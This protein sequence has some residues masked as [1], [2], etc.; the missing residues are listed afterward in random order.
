MTQGR[1]RPV[2]W[3]PPRAGSGLLVLRGQTRMAGL[4][5]PARPRAEQAVAR[6]GRTEPQPGPSGTRPGHGFRAW[7]ASLRVGR[8]GCRFTTDGVRLVLHRPS[9][10][11]LVAASRESSWPSVILH[12]CFFNFR[13]FHGFASSNQWA[14]ETSGPR[15][16]GRAEESPWWSLLQPTRAG[17][18]GA[19]QASRCSLCPPSLSGSAGAEAARTARVPHRRVARVAACL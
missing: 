2:S 19:G 6:T 7:F 4:S 3:Q 8:Q 18:H 15:P 14:A 1:L 5:L 11:P 17:S 10:T 12:L 16:V 9:L 13:E